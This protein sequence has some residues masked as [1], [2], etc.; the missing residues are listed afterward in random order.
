MGNDKGY[1]KGLGL[2]DIQ[3]LVKSLR[4]P[5]FHGEQIYQWMY[6][7]GVV[8]F[9]AMTNLPKDLLGILEN[10]MELNTLSIDDVQTSIK[11]DTKKILFKTHDNKYIESVSMVDSNRHT[12]CI[13]SQIGCNVDCSFCATGLMGLKRNLSAGEIIDQAILIRE[14]RTIPITNVVFMGMGEPMLN[15]KNVMDASDILHNPIGFNLGNSRITISTSGI[16]PQIKKYIEEKVPYKLA[17][18]LNATSNKVR[19]ELIPINKKWDIDSLL[20]TLDKYPANNRKMLMIE[21]VLIADVNDSKDDAVRLSEIAN[22]LR[23]KLNIIPFNEIGIKY[24]RPSKEKL[25]EFLRVLHKYR[26]HYNILVRWSKGVDIDAACGQ[27][28]INQ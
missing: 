28:A 6:R 12:I 5:E 17:V 22:S 23:C 18:S 7:H 16:L 26:E 15:Y 25:D 2:N 11:E 13:S 9:S 21:Y 27:L 24:K 20:D 3:S 1:I 14:M 19:D 4:F 8:D 10:T